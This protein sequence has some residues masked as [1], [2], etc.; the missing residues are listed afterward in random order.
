[1]FSF[2]FRL[3]ICQQIPEVA[4]DVAAGAQMLA[5]YLQSPCFDSVRVPGIER[6]IFRV[7]MKGESFIEPELVFPDQ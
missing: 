6:K 4:V 3:Q 1:M 7:K 5:L 2:I